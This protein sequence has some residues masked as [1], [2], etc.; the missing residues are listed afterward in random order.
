MCIL[1]DANVAAEFAPLSV[2]ADAKPIMERLL[3]RRLQLAT[4]G[5]LTEEL[6]ATPFRKFLVELRRNGTER[7]YPN[8]GEVEQRLRI[9][10]QCQSNDCHIIA[11]AIVS[12][13]R[14]LFTRDD[15]LKGDFK[16]RDL[17][18]PRG[19][20]YSSARNAGLLNLCPKCK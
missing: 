20:I 6:L 18:N 2:S 12:G 7:S 10:G 11:L 8:V 15:L 1:V 13:S 14:L 19:K 9:E 5:K 4:G 16:N 17:L 3:S